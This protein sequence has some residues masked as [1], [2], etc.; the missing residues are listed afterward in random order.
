MLAIVIKLN[1]QLHCIDGNCILLGRNGTGKKTILNIAASLNKAIVF[2]AFDHTSEA[3]YEC[4]KG[5]PV[6]LMESY[7]R[8]K[9]TDFMSANKSTVY[10][11]IISIEEDEDL[12]EKYITNP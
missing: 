1:N 3:L 10:S 11:N 7:L 5:R 9:F 8:S 2:D 12:E 6:I 4:Y